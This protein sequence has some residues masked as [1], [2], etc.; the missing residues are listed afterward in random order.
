MVLSA[1]RRLIQVSFRRSALRG[2]SVL[3][4]TVAA[5]RIEVD[6]LTGA[7]PSSLE[8]HLSSIIILVEIGRDIRSSSIFILLSDFRFE[9]RVSGRSCIQRSATSC[10]L[11]HFFFFGFFS[12]SGLFLLL[13]LRSVQGAWRPASIFLLRTALI[14]L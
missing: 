4:V 1:G 14:E 5:R 3:L 13:E 10:C 7:G 12:C 9:R 6:L 2:A 8:N 11:V